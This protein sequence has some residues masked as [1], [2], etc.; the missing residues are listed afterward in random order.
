MA[1]RFAA[2]AQTRDDIKEGIRVRKLDA[3]DPA[4]HDRGPVRR[5][6]GGMVP[7][8]LTATAS[9]T[10]GAKEAA[11]LVTYAGSW[12]DISPAV[13]VWLIELNG[14]TLP[15]R[16]SGRRYFAWDSGYDATVSGSTRRVYVADV[17][18]GVLTAVECVAGAL[19]NTYTPVG[20]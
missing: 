10:A 16:T 19:A 3:A 2:T 14:G 8:K 7:V 13:N 18:P 20:V 12:A 5:V 11:R 9:T 4:P 15:D 1:E 17:P 6:S